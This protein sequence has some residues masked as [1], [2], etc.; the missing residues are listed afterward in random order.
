MSDY[1]LSIITPRGKIFDNPVNS[2]V[3]P[4]ANGSFGVLKNHTP[5]VASLEEGVLKINTSNGEIFYKTGSG[6][7]EV[8]DTNEV[9]ILADYA[10]TQEDQKKQ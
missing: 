1:R 9:L 10:N 6:I 3:A 5:F 4:G 7:L 2:L 8:N